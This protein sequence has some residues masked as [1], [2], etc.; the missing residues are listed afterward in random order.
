MS[1]LENAKKY[2][3]KEVLDKIAALGLYEYGLCRQKLSDRL[4]MAAQEADAQ[5][6][7]VAALN[8]ADLDYALLGVL[9]ANPEKVMEGISIAA[10]ALG[11]E[12]QSLYLPESEAGLLESLK[13]AAEKYHVQL[14]SGIVNLRANKGKALLH[15]VTAAE[16]AE[17]FAKEADGSY[18]PG[19][20]VSVNGGE[21]QKAAYGTKVSELA[22]TAGAKALLLGYEYHKPEDAELAVEDAGITNGVVRVLT[23]K[24]CVVAET[25]KMLLSARKQSCG[26]CV[27]CREGL[28]Q[29][30]YMHKEITEGRGKMDFLDL[31]KEIG[32]AMCDSTPCTMGQTCAKPALTAIANF[33]GEYEAHIKKKNCPAGACSSFVNFYIDPQICTGCGDCMDVCPKDCIEGKAKYIHM[34][35]EF[36]CDKCGKCMEACEEGAVKQAT[37]KLPKLPNRLTKVGKFK[38]R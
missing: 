28:I 25:Q 4:A 20:Y 5:S 11:T 8:N 15:I 13:E 10:Y 37:G 26:R 9:K 12:D 38:R 36:D 1:A 32:E 21:I 19:V 16:L 24:D 18:V 34:I 23:E 7:V 17:V 30:E 22:D 29:L 14:V 35:D 3:S 27:F 2:S 33:A 31:S 6:G